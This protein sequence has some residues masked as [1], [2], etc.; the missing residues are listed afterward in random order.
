MILGAYTPN[1]G[2]VEL[3]KNAEVKE[4]FDKALG[5]LV[6]AEYEPVA[7]IARQ[8][9]SGMNYA[10]FCREKTV[11]ADPAVSFS[12]VTVYQDLEGKASVKEV[13]NLV[14]GEFDS[15]E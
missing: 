15:F 4:A 9:V 3:S 12:V 5:E 14:I 1:E 6:G 2:D 7:Y 11:T 10:V 8:V 13:E